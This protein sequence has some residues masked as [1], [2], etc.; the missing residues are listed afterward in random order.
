M[1]EKRTR[2]SDKRP[3]IAK[4]SQ[5]MSADAIAF[6]RAMCRLEEVLVD[7]QR[8][9]EVR[10]A[11]RTGKMGKK[12]LEEVKA[13]LAMRRVGEVAVKTPDATKDTDE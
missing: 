3:D 6:G 11:I 2:K 12:S 8:A 5:A 4:L 13:I 7:A 9:K 1:S 10:E